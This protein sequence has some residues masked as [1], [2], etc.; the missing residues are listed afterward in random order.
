MSVFLKYSKEKKV[1]VVLK[2]K[3]KK[4]QILKLLENIIYD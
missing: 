2:R 3:Q 1:V 4:K